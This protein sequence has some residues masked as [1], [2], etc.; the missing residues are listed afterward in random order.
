M[1]EES[2]VPPETKSKKIE[3]KTN[4]NMTDLQIILNALYKIA[5]YRGEYADDIKRDEEYLLTNHNEDRSK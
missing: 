1:F 5:N 3:E 4:A 2:F